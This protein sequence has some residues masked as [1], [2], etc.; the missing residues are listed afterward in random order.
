MSRSHTVERISQLMSFLRRITVLAQILDI[1]RWSVNIDT[2]V[3]K[4]TEAN[5]VSMLCILV[6]NNKHSQRTDINV[7][8]HKYYFSLPQYLLVGCYFFTFFSVFCNKNRHDRQVTIKHR[9]LVIVLS[10]DVKDTW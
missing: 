8:H 5:I 2:I 7:F 6:P 9:Q 3:Q 1:G 4:Q 10:L